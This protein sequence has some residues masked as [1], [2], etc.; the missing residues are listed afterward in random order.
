MQA[1]KYHTTGHKKMTLLDKVIMLADYIEPYRE[2]YTSLDEIRKYAYT[3][4]DKALYIGTKG[5]IEDEKSKGNA[6]HHWSKDALKVL[7]KTM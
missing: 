4:M 2:D 3:N 7:K 5:T 1:I 6:I